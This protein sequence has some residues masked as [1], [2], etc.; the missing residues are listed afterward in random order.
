MWW[1]IFGTVVVL[2]NGIILFILKFSKQKP[3]DILVV[4]EYK[5][6]IQLLLSDDDY[7]KIDISDIKNDINKINTKIKKVVESRAFELKSLV[8]KVTMFHRDDKAFE[9]EL[10]SVINASYI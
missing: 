5:D 8:S 1:I 7:M 2:A 10:L 4:Y 9:E 3:R 6:Y